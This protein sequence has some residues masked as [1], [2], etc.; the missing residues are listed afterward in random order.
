MLITWI[1]GATTY[2]LCHG[3]ERGAGKAT[4]PISLECSSDEVTQVVR[5]I[6]AATAELHDRQGK[7]KTVEFSVNEQYATIAAAIIDYHRKRELIPR[8]GELRIAAD[9]S[10]TL[11]YANAI[12]DIVGQRQTGLSILWRYRVTAPTT[13]LTTV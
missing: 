9:A 12:L 2:T 11:N 7:L 3:T 5:K 1:N 10:N 4:G 6:R 8:T 13:T